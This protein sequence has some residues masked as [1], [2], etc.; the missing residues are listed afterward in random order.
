MTTLSN[1]L[2]NKPT[3]YQSNNF[4]YKELK[5]LRYCPR[6]RKDKKYINEYISFDIETTK[7]GELSFMYSWCIAIGMDKYITG[8]TWDTFFYTLFKIKAHSKPNDKYVIYVYNLDFEFAFLRGVYDFQPDEV[9]ALAPHRI[10]KCTMYDGMF[11]FRCAHKLAGQ[12][13]N[14]YGFMKQENVPE[15]YLKTGFFDYER[16]RFSDSK[17]KRYE[18]VYIR[19]DCIGLNYAVKH[20]IENRGY[21]VRTTPLTITGFLRVKYRQEMRK[22]IGQNYFTSRQP[23][24]ELI[25]KMHKGFRGGNTH[26]NALYIG[27][28]LKRVKTKD[29]KSSYPASLYK[30][31]YPVEKFKRL[32]EQDLEKELSPRYA[33]LLHIT[34][35]ECE[36]KT[37]FTAVPYIPVAKCITLS[38][39]Y[40]P[41][42]GRVVSAGFLS[43]W[44][45]DIDL[46]IIKN[47]YKGDI[48]V[49]EAWASRYDYLPEPVRQFV[50]DT[51]KGKETIDKKKHP[52][53]YAIY[54]SMLNAI[55]GDFVMYPLKPEMVFGE[56]WT[57]NAVT[58][59]KYIKYCKKNTKLYQWGVWCT[60]NARA[61]LQYIIDR[62]PYEN[63]VYTDTDSIKYLGEHDDVFEE[64]NKSINDA[65]NLGHYM[66][67]DPYIVEEWKG[68]GAKKY[69]Y[70]KGGD[71]CITVAGVPKNGAK[72]LKNL[73][74]FVIG[75]VFS[76]TGKKRVIHNQSYTQICYKN[77]VL[78]VTANATLVDTEYTL[79][80]TKDLETLATENYFIYYNKEKEL[81]R[82]I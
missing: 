46:K 4:P 63:M 18:K 51:F 64:Y 67:D 24:L 35:T 15:Q 3:E 34:I 74:D 42:N 65:L 66:N 48:K 58:E 5:R 7:H 72:E 59:E 81:K 25:E 20:Y 47:Q 43:M 32:R 55:Y 56:E 69:A 53:E 6:S 39:D 12:Q 77:H 68:Y 79:D 71:I 14:L 31:K 73:D 38:S 27:E 13:L 44:V 61:N 57:T 26:Q 49:I 23:Q 60:A 80:I 75:K 50:Y 28:K 52:I 33:Y 2:E 29:I 30:D 40:V 70:M 17:L 19:N 36:L 22:S 1:N 11:E 9:F 10:L 78:N 82:R 8:R 45:T 76:N 54:K 16:D 62:I 41:D 21:N 37:I